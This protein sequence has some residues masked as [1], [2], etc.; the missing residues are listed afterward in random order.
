[1]PRIPVAIVLVLAS[2][3]SA[4]AQAPREIPIGEGLQRERLSL[5]QRRLESARWLP[6]P[7]AS[8][9][10]PRGVVGFGGSP[11]DG[12]NAVINSGPLPPGSISNPY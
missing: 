10:N 12:I 4:L 7:N 6:N 9:G 8:P 5:T 2:A 11:N 3:G 1:M